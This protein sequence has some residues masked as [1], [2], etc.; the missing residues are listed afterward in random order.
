MSDNKSNTKADKLGEGIE[1]L[2]GKINDILASLSGSGFEEIPNPD[3]NVTIDGSG[4]SELVG[5]TFSVDEGTHASLESGIEGFIGN[6]GISGA[7]N[8]S[9][10][11]VALNKI[12]SSAREMHKKLGHVTDSVTNRIQNV[13]SLQSVINKGFNKLYELIKLNEKV[14]DSNQSQAKVIK[15]VQDELNSEMGK[16]LKAL[17][18]IL[19]LKIKPKQEELLELLRKNASFTALAEKLGVAYNDTE[20]SD[21]LALAYTNMSQLGLISKEVK[22]SLNVLKISLDKYKSIKNLHSLKDTLTSTLKHIK[23]SKSV[24]ELSKIV[25]AM[26]ILGKHQHNHDEIANYLSKNGRNETEGSYDVD[27]INMGSSASGGD[28]TTGIGRVRNTAYKSNLSS[29]VKTYEKTLK[30]LFKNFLSQITLNFTDIRKDVEV[31]SD[32]LGDEIPYND[33]IKLFIS[34]FEGF[35]VDMENEKLFYALIGLDTTVAGKEVKQRFSDNLNR[36]IESLN[37]LKSHKYLADIRH[38]LVTTKEN[39]DTY[40]DTV[41]SIKSAEETKKGSA[42]FFWTDKLVD[43]SLPINVTKIIKETIVKLKFYGNVSMIKDNLHRMTKEHVEYQADYLKTLGKSIGIKLSELQREYVEQVDRLN[44]KERGRGWLLDTYNA[45]A[46]PDNKIP[47]GLI[48]TIYKLQYDAKVGLYKTVEAVDLYL[49]DFSEKLSGDIEAI[50][51]LSVMLKQTEIISKWF[52]RKS[53]TNIVALTNLITNDVKSTI[54]ALNA[55]DFKS[56]TNLSAEAVVTG[57]DMKKILEASKKAI[58]SVS[59]LKNIISMFVH[60]GDKFG[61]KSLSSDMYMS[62]NIIYKN[63]I[64]YIWVSAFTMGYGTA[65][66]DINAEINSIK[67]DKAGYEIERGDLASFFHLKPTVLTTSL[68]TLK[69]QENGLRAHLKQAKREALNFLLSPVVVPPAGFSKVANEQQLIELV[70]QK[71]EETGA[72]SLASIIRSYGPGTS[73]YLKNFIRYADAYHLERSIRN[74]IFFNEDKYFILTLKGITA[75]ILTVVASSNLINRPASVVNMITNPVR[76]IIGGARNP[77]VIDEAVELYIRLPLLVEFYKNIFDNGNDPYKRNKFENDETETIAFIP[78]VGSKWSG[79]IQCIFDESKNIN[80]GVYGI[81]NMNRIINEVNNIYKHYKGVDHTKLTRTVILDLVA[82]INRRYGVLKR[83]EIN[84]FYQIKKKYT[85]NMEDVGLVNDVNFDILDDT[86]EFEDAG[87]SAQ[88]TEN[89]FNKMQNNSNKV[90]QNDINIVKDFR[91]KIH[92]ELFSKDLAELSK[93]SFVEKVKHYKSEISNTKSN[94]A[95]VELILKAIDESSNINSHDTDINLMFHELVMY[96]IKNLQVLQNWFYSF[97]IAYLPKM[98]YTYQRLLVENEQNNYFTEPTLIG[99]FTSVEDFKKDINANIINPNKFTERV[100]TRLNTSGVDINTVIRETSLVYADLYAFIRFLSTDGNYFTAGIIAAEL[101]TASALGGL[102]AEIAAKVGESLQGVTYGTANSLLNRNKALI[103]VSEFLTDNT[104]LAETIKL[105]D[106]AYDKILRNAPAIQD[107]YY[108]ILC[109]DL[110]DGFE[111]TKTAIP[112][113][114]LNKVTLINIVNEFVSD[115]NL[116]ELKFVTTNKFI[117]DYSKLQTLVE[118]SIENAKYMLSKF[119][120]QAPTT[121]IK[122]YETALLEIEDKLLLKVIT[123]QDTTEDPLFAICNLEQINNSFGEIVNGTRRVNLHNDL[124]DSIMFDTRRLTTRPNV[125]LSTVYNDPKHKIFKEVF[126]YYDGSLRVWKLYNDPPAGTPASTITDFYMYPGLYLDVED[127]PGY[128]N[129][130]QLL[131]KFNSLIYMYLNV[132]YDGSTK[133]IYNGLFNEFAN[134]SQNGTI[135]GNKGVADIVPAVRTPLSMNETFVNDDVVLAES[136]ALMF[137]IFINRVTNFQLPT[138]YHL[139]MTINEVSPNMVEKYKTFLPIFINMFESL[140]KKCIIYKKILD[141]TD[142][143]RINGRTVEAPL[144]MGDV[145]ILADLVGENQTLKGDWIIGSNHSSMHYGNILTNLIEASRAIINDANNVLNEIPT[146]PQFFELKENFI[147]NFFNNTGKLPL[148]PMSTLSA[149]LNNGNDPLRPDFV[150]TNLL[151][152]GEIVDK[153]NKFLYGS[154]S[155][156][157]SKSQDNDLN[158]YLWLKNSIKDYNNSVVAVNKL[159]VG[160]VSGYLECNNMLSRF[161]YNS[162]YINRYFNRSYGAAFALKNDLKESV[163]TY[164]TLQNNSMIN[165][166]SVIENSS[167]EN[168]KLRIANEAINNIAIHNSFN[169]NRANARLLNIIDLNIIPINVHALMREIPLINIYNYAFT[170]DNIVKAE[171]GNFGPEVTQLPSN[172]GEM[173][174]Y[175]LVDPYYVNHNAPRMIVDALKFSVPKLDKPKFL[176]DMVIPQVDPHHL[177]NKFVRNVIFLVNLQ[178]II[179]YK[180]KK[181]VEH[182]DTK[183]V[184]DIGILNDRIT[185]YTPEHPTHKDDDFEYLTL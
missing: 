65:G 160:K 174:A 69:K 56:S 49:M 71:R 159:D 81:E 44:D 156:I 7:G 171:F 100:I 3:S 109:K 91:D 125:Q 96:P 88:F 101:R 48:E 104:G 133:K 25:K 62:P 145:E 24:E 137:K 126:K 141:T 36:L 151:P 74:D 73:A 135:F 20:A 116:I 77:E 52:D 108:K 57:K 64:K 29:R 183:I 82:E 129:D 23:D 86:N 37:V 123:N 106:D 114:A 117:L 51:E 2:E 161:Y 139:L 70:K 103:A 39:I 164:H 79:I 63:L 168:S 12:G 152:S 22:D 95:K 94:E 112:A 122:K 182:I 75:K 14:T 181:E 136:L 105:C 21:R 138:K 40:S 43:Y 17:E 153:F 27:N 4:E 41:L 32:Q 67:K 165:T 147:K 87:P 10:E 15:D 185:A 38:Q 107:T 99:K 84:E 172:N 177:N 58:E 113:S 154:N 18:N 45:S 61:N 72:G 53:E 131:S 143:F 13:H 8:N 121:T 42:E 93:K 19:N 180:I 31:V 118:R 78:E 119:R 16:Q 98:Y 55:L 142:P 134:K 149:L 157:N 35:A 80:N 47:R 163:N 127:R 170:Y 173:L 184:K 50:K 92:N 54:S 162:F 33:D 6:E 150:Y 169:L 155:V 175:L 26:E 83:R 111:S 30:E 9:L 28:Y 115:N 76:T 167:L 11:T 158:S 146:K 46:T 176:S 166:I 68:D 102:L 148:M 90:L 132:F 130:K 124:Y 140:I 1:Q 89:V 34:I 66:G 97:L 5:G 85:R 179:I 120:N 128:I 178:R 59:V 110:R 144:A 60:I